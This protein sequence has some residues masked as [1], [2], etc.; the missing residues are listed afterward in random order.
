MILADIFHV[1]N[2]GSL[3]IIVTTLGV[4]IALSMRATR[5]QK[6]AKGTKATETVQ[7]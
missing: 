5:G 6:K 7:K 3:A 4:T 2:W 1:P